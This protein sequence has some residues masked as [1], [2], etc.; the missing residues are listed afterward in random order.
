ML[1]EKKKNYLFEWQK[2]PSRF[3]SIWKLFQ[4]EIKSFKLLIDIVQAKP[5]SS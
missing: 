1:F 5:E 2:K 3:G 4:F